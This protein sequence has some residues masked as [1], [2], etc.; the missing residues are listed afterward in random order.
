MFGSVC[1]EGEFAEY[2]GGDGVTQ[3]F[4]GS[5]YVGGVAEI[6]PDERGVV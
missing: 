6:Q 1:R 4:E 3:V 5:R 2:Y